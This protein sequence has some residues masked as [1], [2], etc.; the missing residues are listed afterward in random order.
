MRFHNFAKWKSSSKWR[1]DYFLW[2]FPHLAW[3]ERSWVF[4]LCFNVV[5]YA[6]KKEGDNA[7]KEVENFIEPH[8]RSVSSHLWAVVKIFFYGIKIN[9][10]YT[11]LKHHHNNHHSG[12]TFS[13]N[14]RRILIVPFSSSFPRPSGALSQKF[15]SSCWLLSSRARIFSHFPILVI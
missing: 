1:R 15:T 10:I 13:S 7:R 8:F 12:M 11:L 3:V 14:G 9:V 2:L 6:W 4:V 5:I